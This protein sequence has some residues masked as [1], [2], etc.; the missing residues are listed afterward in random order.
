MLVKM[1][2]DPITTDI[3][4]SLDYGHVYGYLCMNA[5]HTCQDEKS[6]TRTYHVIWHWNNC[7]GIRRRD[8]VQRDGAP[9]YVRGIC[10]NAG[11]FSVW[12]FGNNSILNCAAHKRD[13][14]IV[15]LTLLRWV[16]PHFPLWWF[17]FRMEKLI[18]FQSLSWWWWC[19]WFTTYNFLC[20]Q[21][22]VYAMIIKVTK[23]NGVSIRSYI[24][25]L[26]MNQWC[27]NHLIYTVKSWYSPNEQSFRSLFWFIQIVV[28]CVLPEK[29]LQNVNGIIDHTSFREIFIEHFNFPDTCLSFGIMLFCD[30]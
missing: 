4:L 17:C 14:L 1:N 8:R 5:S 28:K 13:L 11:V 3:F 22:S 29:S 20:S 18:F 12:D 24:F 6:P 16:L 21:P 7:P 30:D 10:M 26:F 15:P 2:G 25:I 23:T 9:Q 19:D 27:T